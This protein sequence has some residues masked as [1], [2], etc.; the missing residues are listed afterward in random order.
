M[1][2]PAALFTALAILLLRSFNG[3]QAPFSSGPFV[4][5]APFSM[6]DPTAVFAG[7]V[8]GKRIDGITLY[9]IPLS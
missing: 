2:D 8:G 7:R 6:S 5:A 9:L 4:W 3:F 1:A